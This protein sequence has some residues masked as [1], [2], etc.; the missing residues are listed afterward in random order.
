MSAA[1]ATLLNA[2]FRAAFILVRNRDTGHIL[3]PLLSGGYS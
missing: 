3:R 1:R 2:L